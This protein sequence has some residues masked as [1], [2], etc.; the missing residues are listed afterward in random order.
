MKITTL[1]Q[2][3]FAAVLCF[4][5][6]LFS[7]QVYV[8][9][10]Q[11]V[12]YVGVPIPMTIVYENIEKDGEPTIPDI[13]GFS[14]Q[15]RAGEHSSTQTTIINGKVTSTKTTSVTYTLT[16][17]REGSFTIPV[18]TFFAGGKAFPTTPK[19]LTIE[20]PP[21]GGAL[22]AEV[23]GT[24]GELY[25]GRPIDLTLRFFIEQFTDPN[26]G[27]H[28]DAQEMFRRIRND[29]NFG[30]FT[31]PLQDGNISAQREQGVNDNGAPATFFVYSVQATAWP[32][33]TGE[34]ALP[35]ITILADYPISISKQQ[36]GGFFSGSQLVVDQSQLVS[37]QATIPTI[38]VLTP[39]VQN[40][41]AWYSGAV[42]NF[43][44]RIVAEPT[45]VKVGEPIMLS[46]RVTDLTS[47]KVNLDY[48]A[49]PLLDRVPAL[50]D[51]FKVPDKTLGGVVS[52]RTKTF[53]QTLRPRNNSP[54]E[55]P[56]LPFS[57][58]NPS[59]GEYLTS[60]S[61]PIPLHV[62]AVETISANDLVGS[63]RT[64]V[65]PTKPIEVKGGI[66]ANYTGDAL[67]NS[68]Q[69]SMTPLLIISVAFPPFAFTAILIF[70]ASR[71]H[72]R[73]PSSKRKGASKRA[74]RTLKNATNIAQDEQAAHI[75]KALRALQ[76][77][78]VGDVQLAKQMDAL[79]Q[80]C[81]ASQFGGLLDTQ[82]AK[83]AA[84][85]VEQIR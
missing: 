19:R 5:A 79:L 64:S 55:I 45:R 83:D 44:F 50:T 32:E 56:S 38:E 34:L 75:S 15:K 49:A 33:T 72:A 60:W 10:R 59:T 24:H 25:L 30:I 31:K 6:Q 58:F 69:V 39:P 20:A 73:L 78:H 8:D 18:L 65:S 81:D 28:L 14:V 61:K 57:S 42:G 13:D 77:E 17:L 7:Q 82:L 37:A 84:S 35:S 29:S 76:S 16:P 3:T 43:D 41:P 85:L 47:G 1:I 22:R 51:N 66:L 27:I 9:F 26:L 70:I 46:M 52:G 63:N 12:G 11:N 4:T 40:R 23:S 53:T 80:R 54:T 36:R 68:E 62:D 2:S 71:K 74:T 21:T 48:L 67:L